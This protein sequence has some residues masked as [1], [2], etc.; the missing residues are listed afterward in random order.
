VVDACT[1][2]HFVVA[3]IYPPTGFRPAGNARILPE[4]LKRRYRDAKDL[5]AALKR[6]FMTCAEKRILGLAQAAPSNGRYRS[7][8]SSA[9]APDGRPGQPELSRGLRSHLQGIRQYSTM[10]CPQK[11]LQ[12]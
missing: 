6:F 9:D 8:T 3:K 12:G 1:A 7:T 5:D 11:P 4:N 2:R 10:T